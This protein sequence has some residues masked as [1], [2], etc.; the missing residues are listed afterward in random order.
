M[1]LHYYI[2]Y[3]R[4]LSIPDLVCL[5]VRPSVPLSYFWLRPSIF[6]CPPSID[7]WQLKPNIQEAPLGRLPAPCAMLLLATSFQLLAM[8][9]WCFSFQAH[10]YTDNIYCPLVKSTCVHTVQLLQHSTLYKC[11]V[12]L[13]VR[14][15]INNT[16]LY[17]NV[18]FIPI[19][20]RFT[21]GPHVNF[22]EWTLG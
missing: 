7:F 13:I 21:H 6:C 14:V 10:S 8:G 9:R 3:W 18:V 5:S 4:S 17:S 11:S 2:Y 19:G 1:G 12:S 15:G 22:L 16:A 20:N